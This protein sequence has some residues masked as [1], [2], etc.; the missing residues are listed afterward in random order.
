MHPKWLAELTSS[1][2]TRA[3]ADIQPLDFS[4]TSGGS[5]RSWR[6]R[7]QTQGSEKWG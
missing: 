5:W 3:L 1:P 6:V 4:L 7:S 2:S